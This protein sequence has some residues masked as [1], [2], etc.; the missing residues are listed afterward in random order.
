MPHLIW[1][2]NALLDMQRLYRFLAEKNLDAAKRAVKAIRA[3]VKVLRNQ[4]NIGRAARLPNYREWPIDFGGSG[5]M[6]LYNY[7]DSDVLIVAVRHQK[8]L[9]F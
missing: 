6:V 9:E 7:N 8:E 5:Y 4:P 2:P 3:G 1:T